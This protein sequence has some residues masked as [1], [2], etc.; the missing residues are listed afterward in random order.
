MKYFEKCVYIIVF[1]GQSTEAK[2]TKKKS[3]LFRP[4]NF[5]SNRLW[6]NGGYAAHTGGGSGIVASTHTTV[7]KEC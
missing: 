2:L 5:P 3:I 6:G 7:S 1:I 4:Q